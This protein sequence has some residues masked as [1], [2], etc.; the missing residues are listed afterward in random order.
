MT[1]NAVSIP[2]L[3]L[4]A[5]C[6]LSSP[7]RAEFASDVV[8]AGVGFAYSGANPDGSANWTSEDGETASATYE[9]A[10]SYGLTRAQLKRFY[11]KAFA[12]DK[13]KRQ[14]GV[15]AAAQTKA[16]ETPESKTPAAAQAQAGPAFVTGACPVASDC[17]G[18]PL[19][20][21]PPVLKEGERI[22]QMPNGLIYVVDAKGYP[23]YLVGKTAPV[24]PTNP[25]YT[26]PYV[27]ITGAK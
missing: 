20:D 3:L 11:P 18:K 21:A 1:M 22:S 12:Q 19:S 2:M 23:Q 7:A 13:T 25:N 24:E 17:Q 8:I 14:R 6:A 4:A 10:R 9:E 5:S 15:A 27:T 16:G 26:K